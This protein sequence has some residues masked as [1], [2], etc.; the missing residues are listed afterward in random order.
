M[1]VRKLQNEELQNLYSSPSV[2]TMIKS[3]RIRWAEH[4]ACMGEKRNTHRILVEK[5]EG[6]TPLGRTRC[7][8]E[9]NIKMVLR[10]IGWDDMD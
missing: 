5:L 3:R 7:R 6:E 10:A 9:A 2:I 4:I 8:L 1:M